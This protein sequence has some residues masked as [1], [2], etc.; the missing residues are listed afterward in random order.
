MLPASGQT[1]EDLDGA[2][3]PQTATGAFPPANAWPGAAST[4]ATN[5]MDTLIRKEAPGDAAGIAAVTASA[6]LDAAHTDHTEQFI[7]SALREAGQLTVS[8]VAVD[9][10]AIIGHVAISPV[11]VSGRYLGWFGLGPVSVAPAWQ[12]RGIGSAL[13]REALAELGSLRA[14]GC[15][16]LGE[17][18]FYSRF[19]FRHEPSLVLPGVPPEYFQAM[20]FTG[21]PPSGVVAYHESFSAKG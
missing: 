8:L 21:D 2:I 12:G 5:P 7:V 4:P 3:R 16:V 1:N 18:G 10:G 11:S 9:G 13:V 14:S 17:P 6:F 20:I 15:V 19:G